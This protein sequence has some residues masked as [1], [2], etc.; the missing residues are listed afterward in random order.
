[1]RP[2]PTPTTLLITLTAITTPALSQSWERGDVLVGDAALDRFGWIVE[3][4][5][6]VNGDGY[7]DVVASALPLSAPGYVHVFFGGPDADDTPDLTFTGSDPNEDFGASVDGAGD[8]NGDGYDDVVVGAPEYASGDGRAYI[9]FGGTDGDVV[10]DVI[11]NGSGFSLGDVV[12]GAGDVNGDGYDDVLVAMP[13]YT[14]GVYFRGRVQLVLG[15]STPDGIPDLTFTGD[16]GVHEHLGSS[17]AGGDV[18]FDGR[19][20]VVIGAEAVNEVKVFFGGAALDSFQDRTLVGPLTSAFGWRVEVADVDGDG[21]QDVV[22]AASEDDTAFSSAGRIYV[23]AGGPLFDESWDLAIDGNE[24]SRRLGT[25]LACGDAD[26]DGIADIIAGTLDALVYVYRGGAALDG[27]ADLAIPGRDGDDFF[28]LQVGFT[29]TYH[30]DGDPV[31]LAG[32]NQAGGS[33]RGTVT[34]VRT[35]P[36]RLLAPGAGDRW[37]AGETATI[38]WRGRD[39]ADV[40]LSIDGGLTWDVLASG[41]GGED[42]NPLVVHAPDVETDEAFVRV[43]TTGVP[44][45]AGTSEVQLAPFSIGRT[46]T[47]AWTDETLVGATFLQSA[48]IVTEAGST[49]I[50]TGGPP[51]AQV[52]RRG[53]TG[54]DAELIDTGTITEP[55]LTRGPDGRLHAAYAEEE[56][57]LRY[58]VHDGSAWTVEPIAPSIYYQPSVGVDESGTTHIIA[59]SDDDTELIHALDTGGGWIVSPLGT[60]FSGSRDNG[61]AVDPA[62]TAHAAGVRSISSELVYLRWDGSWSVP[63]VVDVGNVGRVELELGPDRLPRITY[64]ERTSDE[65][66]IARQNPDG[67]WSLDTVLNVGADVIQ[68][69]SFAIAGDGAEYLALQLPGVADLAVY[70]NAGDGWMLL[71]LDDGPESAG[72]AP[73]LALDGQDNPRVVHFDNTADRLRYRT[74]AVEL[75][76]PTEPGDAW[77]VGA[78]RSLDVSGTGRVDLVLSVDGG[79]TWQPLAAGVGPGL[80]EFTVPNVPTR[81]ARVEARRL[82]PAPG[83][84]DPWLTGSITRT[85]GTFTIEADI[86]AMFFRLDLA[87]GTGRPVLRWATEPGLEDLRGYDVERLTHGTWSPLAEELRAVELVLAP[88][89]DADRYRLIAVD[90]LGRRLLVAEIRSPTSAVLSARP[91]PMRGDALVVTYRSFGAPGGAPTEVAVYDVAG[92]RVATLIDEPIA[93][94]YHETTW[95]GRD[96]AGARVQSG[97]YFIRLATPYGTDTLKIVRMP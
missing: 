97:I 10:A 71:D 6:D 24:P 81:Y 89:A 41:V 21:L 47:L 34:L 70:R 66:R 51:G 73:S 63:E 69:M 79:A 56:V 86:T 67:S 11:V 72:F 96:A 94:G 29:P 57:E 82:D 90:G 83:S 60:G 27:T 65:V 4:A 77:P 80:V 37:N 28:G 30:D 25:D 61:L 12:G 93:E 85:E 2:H 16:P 50:L 38:R 84:G 45:T 40:A 95:D 92:R 33:T 75:G 78:V 42:E 22:V 23:Y 20:D 59:F 35:Y 7:G 88:D 8:V 62:G 18:N 31:V 52:L 53:R 36:Y 5:G 46:R 43:S 48:L 17:L 1:M 91:R 64:Q 3:G 76:A 39:L 68:P 13:D 49:V 74:T 87:N 14:D 58:A 19:V 44:V 32:D 15:G 54:W 26:G 55:D 9:F